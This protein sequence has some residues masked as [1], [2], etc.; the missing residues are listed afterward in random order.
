MKH[1]ENHHVSAEIWQINI[2]AT[3]TT[4]TTTTIT[5]TTSYYYFYC[6]FPFT[7]GYSTFPINLIHIPKREP[8]IGHV[9]HQTTSSRHRGHWRA[10]ALYPDY[11]QLVQT[12]AIE[13]PFHCRLAVGA[14]TFDYN[15]SLTQSRTHTFVISD[16]R[17][18]QE[19][20]AAAAAAATG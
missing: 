7:F 15:H 17:Y 19:T 8:Q 12:L 20:S 13:R 4:T 2:P 14:F 16:V 11:F 1:R 3:T 18:Q 10:S 9:V 5:T 6:Y